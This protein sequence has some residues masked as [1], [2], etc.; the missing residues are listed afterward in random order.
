MSSAPSEGPKGVDTASLPEKDQAHYDS[1]THNGSD[2]NVAREAEERGVDVVVGLIAGHGEGSD[3]D[4]QAS[5]RL[6]RKLDMSILPLIFLLYMLQYIDKQSLGASSILVIIPDNHLTSNQYNNL[7]T[8]FYI[9]YIIFVGPRACVFLGLQAACH[10]YGGLFALRVLLGASEGCITT[11]VTTTMTMLYTQVE[12]T[13]RLPWTFMCNGIANIIAAFISFGVAHTKATAHPRQWQWYMMIVSILSVLVSILYFWRMP[14][15]PATAR[16]LNEQEKIDVNGVEAKV[17]K[18]YQFI[19]ALTDP[20]TWLFFLFAA[21]SNLQGGINVEYGLIIKGF[22]FNSL[23]T[24]LLSIPLG[25]AMVVSITIGTVLIKFFPN[26]RC[27][28]AIMGFIPCSISCL[29]LMFLPWENKSGLL[30]AFYLIGTDI[31]GFI[32][33]LSLVAV[34]VSGHTKVMGIR[35]PEVSKVLIISICITVFL[36]NDLQRNLPHWIFDWSN[37]LFTG[38]EREIPTPEHG[39]MDHRACTILVSA[40][41][42]TLSTFI[43]DIFMICVIRW[44]LVSENN[45]RDAEKLASGE[46]YDEFGYVEHTQEDGSIIKFKVPIQFMD[47]TNK[48]NRAF[49]YPL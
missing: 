23:Q 40:Y 22:G 16:F 20:K 42:S 49:R 29:L 11:G 43:F 13:R 30:V 1:E 47:I 39:A 24:T 3:P 45:R 18:R 2:K 36:E 26:S 38:L 48:E 21:V 15:N 17:W 19:E 27:I 46:E 4:L 12:S 34:A 33:I 32:M 9:G 28:L 5:Y 8:A 31:L 10:S 14:D 35:F 44:Y 25:G 41:F 37:A 6:R 7:S